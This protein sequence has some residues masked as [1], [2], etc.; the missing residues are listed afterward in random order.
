MFSFIF[1]NTNMS[2]MKTRAKTPKC[3]L[4]IIFIRIINVVYVLVSPKGSTK[5]LY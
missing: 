4:N 5:C 3:H 1:G 2:S